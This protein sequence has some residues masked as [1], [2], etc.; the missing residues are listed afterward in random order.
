MNIGIIFFKVT[1]HFLIITINK[2]WRRDKFLCD[3]I[4][5]Y[6]GKFFSPNYVATDQNQ[7]GK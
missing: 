3:L 2:I 5:L 4:I 1:D 6:I 7:F